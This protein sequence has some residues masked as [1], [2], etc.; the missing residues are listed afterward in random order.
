MTPAGALSPAEV[1]EAAAVLGLRVKPPVRRV[2]DVPEVHRG[3]LLAVG[4]GMVRIT[5]GRAVAVDGLAAVGDAGEEPEDAT[6][7]QE[8]ILT[9]RLEGFLQICADAS[10]RRCPGTLQWLVLLVLGPGTRR[11]GRAAPGHPFGVR[12]LGPGPAG[13]AR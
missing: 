9:G 13:A 7:T 5:S 10:G 2:A 6:G 12:A 11:V 8:A 1:P 4:L 3:W